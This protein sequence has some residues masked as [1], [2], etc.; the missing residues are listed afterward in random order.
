[1]EAQVPKDIHFFNDRQPRRSTGHRITIASDMHAQQ[2]LALRRAGSAS[3]KDEFDM[4]HRVAAFP[5]VRMG[6]WRR[7]RSASQELADMMLA[8]A[9]SSTVA[10]K[11]VMSVRSCGSM[12]LSLLW[13]Q[14][15]T[16]M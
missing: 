4:H 8:P 14:L 5:P 12:G 16:F 10:R 1:M 3:S 15:D 6:S 2:Q 9:P 13:G 11:P 7:Y